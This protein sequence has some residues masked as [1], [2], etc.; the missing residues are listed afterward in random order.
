MN[1]DTDL[2]EISLNFIARVRQGGQ[3]WGLRSEGGWAYCESSEYEET[4]VLVFWSDRAS[5]EKHSK[6]EWAG[7]AAEAIALEEFV[8]KWLPGMD[9]DGVLIG[10][11]WDLN[12]AGP[13][14]EPSDL[15]EAFL[16]EDEE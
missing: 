16:T 5:A 2:D 9:E 10:P 13:E 1:E 7:H 11:D 14:V 15:A 12:L 3:V 8:E 6:G 4:D